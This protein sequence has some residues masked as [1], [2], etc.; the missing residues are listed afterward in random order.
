M[1]FVG[2]LVGHSFVS[3]LRAHLI[4][5]GRNNSP[6]N[7]QQTRSESRIIAKKLRLNELLDSLH[8][9]EYNGTQICKMRA[10]ISPLKCMTNP[11]FILLN[12]GT[13]DLAVGTPPLEVAIR[14]V[15]VSKTLMKEIPSVKQIVLI[16]AIPR[17]KNM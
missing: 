8:L 7:T 11:D 3:G 6:Q 14:L 1:K 5:H 4:V 17:Y 9:I 2:C 16:S 10:Y 12:L 13:N 15:E